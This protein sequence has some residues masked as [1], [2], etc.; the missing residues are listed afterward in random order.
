[1]T[2]PRA[3]IRETHRRSAWTV[4]CRAASRSSTLLCTIQVFDVKQLTNVGQCGVG[5]LRLAQVM[6]FLELATT[7]HPTTGLDH[8]GP[9]LAN[10]FVARHRRRTADSL[11]ILTGNV[12]GPNAA[13][14]RGV[15]EAVV[16]M[17]RIAHAGP[18]IARERRPQPPSSF[19]GVSSIARHSDIRRTLPH[20]IDQRRHAL[21]QGDASN[22]TACCGRCAGRSAPEC[23]PG[24]S[25]ASDRQND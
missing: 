23:L 20:Q 14:I 6:A 12:S 13:P 22:A 9:K 24:D 25:T 10:A 2:A 7:M 3:T 1:M 5:L 19:T 16:R 21:R 15:E 11:G 4:A 18:Q 8:A 17:I